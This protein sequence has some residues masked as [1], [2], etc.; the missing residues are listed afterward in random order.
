MNSQGQMCT[1]L[2]NVDLAASTAFILRS[3]VVRVVRVELAEYD[4]LI[5]CHQL[6]V[7]GFSR[8]VCLGP[9]AALE[10]ASVFGFVVGLSLILPDV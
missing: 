8:V 4:S 10:A 3:R 1:L 2:G 5:F 7:I 6:L 9:E